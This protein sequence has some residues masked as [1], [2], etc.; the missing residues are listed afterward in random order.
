MKRD[1]RAWLHKPRAAN[2]LKALLSAPNLA[3]RQ[4]MKHFIKVCVRSSPQNP[5][6]GQNSTP[7]GFTQIVIL[8]LS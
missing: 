3:G 6:F 5:W 2:K 8:L 7:T 4:T 1:L